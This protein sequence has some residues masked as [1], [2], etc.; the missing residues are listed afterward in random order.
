MARAKTAQA[1]DGMERYDDETINE[2]KEGAQGDD[3]GDAKEGNQGLST[4]QVYRARAGRSEMNPWRNY[5]RI[6]RTVKLSSKTERNPG[7]IP[8]EEK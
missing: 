5:L 4:A 2:T 6:N 7:N 3:Q 8:E 1:D